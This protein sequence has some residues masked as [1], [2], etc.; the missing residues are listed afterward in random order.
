MMES[1]INKLCV[2]CLVALLSPVMFA[3]EKTQY[4]YNSHENEI[5]PDANA[6][7]REGN[8]ERA[9]ELCKWYYIIV[10]NHSSDSLREK[11]ERCTSLSKEMESLSF[12]GRIGEAREIATTILSLN[13]SDSRAKEIS[14]LSDPPKSGI[15]SLSKLVPKQLSEQPADT[16]DRLKDEESISRLQMD[17]GSIVSNSVIEEHPVQNKETY[18]SNSETSK[19]EVTS[20]D[21]KSL[22]NRVVAKGG[23]SVFRSERKNS[24]VYGSGQ[25][26]RYRYGIIPSFSIGV[27]DIDGTRIGGEIGFESYDRDETSINTAFVY[28]LNRSF[29]TKAELGFFTDSSGFDG[30]SL[31]LGSTFIISHCFAIEISAKHFLDDLTQAFLVPSIKLGLTF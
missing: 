13:P 31:G 7:F 2:C 9:I 20:T 8:Y 1:V 10:G 19:K 30:M 14:Q 21:K 28:R 18:K 6:S 11:A 4:Y 25:P 5:L 17:N 24:V 12:A 3:Q 23:I 16:V 29:Y 26:G 15:S 22:R 27:Y